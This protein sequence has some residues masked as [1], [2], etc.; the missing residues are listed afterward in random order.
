MKNTQRVGFRDPL[1]VPKH[2]DQCELSSNIDCR[3][4][5]GLVREMNAV[6]CKAWFL[7]LYYTGSSIATAECQFSEF[8]NKNTEKN[9]QNHSM[10]SAA[11]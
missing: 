2:W 11:H 7:P 3:G 4:W 5:T 1:V 6:F 9:A 10:A 8:T